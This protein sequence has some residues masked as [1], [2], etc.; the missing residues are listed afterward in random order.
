LQLNDGAEEHAGCFMFVS[1]SGGRGCK[2][3]SREL[4]TNFVSVI[5]NNSQLCTQLSGPVYQNGGNECDLR[6]TISSFK[7]LNLKGSG[8]WCVTLRIIGFVG[9]VHHSEF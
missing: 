7:W 1:K 6:A 2:L 8:Q 5:A 3:L 9:S 4:L